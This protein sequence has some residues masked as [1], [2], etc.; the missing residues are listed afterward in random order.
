MAWLPVL[1]IVGAAAD[2]PAA[3]PHDRVRGDVSGYYFLLPH[4]ADW[5]REHMGDLRLGLKPEQII[6]ALARA[7]FTDLRHEP[8]ADRHRV[9]TPDDRV[10]D[11]PMFAVCGRKPLP[12]A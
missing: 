10:T 12:R 1:A 3:E 11:F 6:G 9:A 7:G 2:V 4:E 8:L 5:M